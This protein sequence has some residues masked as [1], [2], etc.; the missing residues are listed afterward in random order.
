MPRLE[1]ESALLGAI[2]QK[3]MGAEYQQR[4][5]DEVRQFMK[6]TAKNADTERESRRARIG[7]LDVEIENYANATG[8]GLKSAT[9]LE[10]LAATESER[11][12]LMKE[13]EGSGSRTEKVVRCLPD[14][15]VR[16]ERIVS[17]MERGSACYR[18]MSCRL[19]KSCEVS[20]ATSQ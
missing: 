2:K 4:F 6:D 3:L 19:V 12:Q 16:Y 7:R 17:E 10:R 9:L 20:W 11:A 1:L 14:L 15:S 5:A 8:G 13:K 18:R